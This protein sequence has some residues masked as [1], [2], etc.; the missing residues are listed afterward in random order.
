MK[1]SKITKSDS[2]KVVLTAILDIADDS[3]FTERFASYKEAYNWFYCR[4][5]AFCGHYTIIKIEI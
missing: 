4:Y 2:S 1:T 5:G 3:T